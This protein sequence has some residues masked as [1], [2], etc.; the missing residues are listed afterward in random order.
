MRPEPALKQQWDRRA[1]VTPSRSHPELESPPAGVTPNLESP[2][3]GV[4]PELESPRART[5]PG[6]VGMKGRDGREN[7]DQGHC[8]AMWLVQGVSR[9][10]SRAGQ[11]YSFVL[12]VWSQPALISHLGG[13]F[14]CS[15]SF[16]FSGL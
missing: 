6:V 9:F 2:Q 15:S 1:G 8:D 5:C 10:H 7:R 11:I 14:V 12:R 4:T 13:S 3:F 16:F